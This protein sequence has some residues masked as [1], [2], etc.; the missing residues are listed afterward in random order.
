M[1]EAESFVEIGPTRDKF[2]SSKPNEMGNGERNHEE[3]KERHSDDGNSNDYT[4]GNGKPRDVKRGSNNPR[5]KGKRIKCLICQG[6]HMARKCFNKL[7][8]LVINKKDELKEEAKPIER[9]TS[10]VNS[11]VLI[12][13]KRNGEKGLMFVDINIAGQK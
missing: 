6:P 5:D 9:N 2:E 7:M 3:Y 11:M 12:P 10:R 8:I 13:K 1:A 4:S